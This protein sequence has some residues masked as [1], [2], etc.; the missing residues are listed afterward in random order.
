MNAAHYNEVLKGD[1]IISPSTMRSSSMT[2]HQ[3]IR[4]ITC[5]LLWPGNSSHLNHAEH[6]ER[7]EMT[8]KS[9]CLI[10]ATLHL[11]H[12]EDCLEQHDFKSCADG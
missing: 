8:T 2:K 12:Q 10:S 7:V 9:R 1:L 11:C 5:V 4:T 6:L 3:A